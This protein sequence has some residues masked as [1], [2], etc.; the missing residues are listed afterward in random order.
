ME[1]KLRVAFYTLGCKLNQAESE[2]LAR[3][4]AEAGYRVVSG[5]GADIYV[6]NKDFC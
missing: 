6:L 4:F 2:F 3:Q 1:T 5:D